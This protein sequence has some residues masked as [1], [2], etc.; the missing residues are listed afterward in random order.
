MG[1][2]SPSQGGAGGGDEAPRLSDLN[3]QYV[4]LLV[5]AAEWREKRQEHQSLA[6][7]HEH[8]ATAAWLAELRA[9]DKL[10]ELRERHQRLFPGASLPRLLGTSDTA[11]G[12]SR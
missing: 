8:M 2:Q 4:R 10:R 7:K 1:G 6:A 11:S 9:D 5:A 3:N 12:G